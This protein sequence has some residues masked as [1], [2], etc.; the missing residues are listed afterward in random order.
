MGYF[1]IFLIFFITLGLAFI[2]IL[3]FPFLLAFPSLCEHW[4]VF[5]VNC[6]G[7]SLL[8][9]FRIK[10]VCKG[11]FPNKAF[12]LVSNHLSYID[13]MLYHS[14]LNCSFLSK[15]EVA[16]WPLIGKIF[17]YIGATYYIDRRK[18]KDLLRVIPLLSGALEAGK[19]ICFFPEGTTSNG[20]ELRKF[21][22]SL[23]ECASRSKVPVVVSS[24]TYYAITQKKD[25]SVHDDVCWWGEESR[26]LDHCLKLFR[27]K[28]QI[29]AYVNISPKELYHK[30]SKVL[31]E[32]C[33][34]ELLDIF[35][36]SQDMKDI[37]DMKSLERELKGLQL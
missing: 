2:Y 22:P 13:I 7:K 26:F 15:I 14:V 21:Y 18:K 23:F 36:P 10:L 4:R 20:K 37:Q 8:R 19:K 6:W 31:S 3:L 30:D 34:E 29:R 9:V 32:M 17:S 16:S 25:F 5:I 35:T 24:I 28:T 1:K 33:R 27:S 11:S 12:L